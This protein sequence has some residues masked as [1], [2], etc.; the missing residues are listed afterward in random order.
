[1]PS[2]GRRAA[3]SSHLTSSMPGTVAATR[4]RRDATAWAGATPVEQHS[5]GLLA[6]QKMSLLVG[7]GPHSFFTGEAK[8]PRLD[9]SLTPSRPGRGN[10]A[11]PAAAEGGSTGL[12]QNVNNNNLPQPESKPEHEEAA[13][14]AGDPD[15]A[16]QNP[17][18]ARRRRTRRRSQTRVATSL[19]ETQLLPK[20]PPPVPRRSGGTSL[21]GYVD[22]RGAPRRPGYV[23]K[24][25][26]PP[27]ALPGV[28]R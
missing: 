12:R 14:D 27:P 9:L 6:D 23:P 3:G 24:A 28:R 15:E 10:G 21:T 7:D 5:P 1:M 4:P 19:K 18:R 17:S 20:A 2:G 8:A 16:P 25:R 11:G 22:D 26:L 13:A